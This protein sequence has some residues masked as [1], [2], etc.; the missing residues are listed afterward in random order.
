MQERRVLSDRKLEKQEVGE[1]KL[2]E[3]I[4]FGDNMN[5]AYKKVRRA[6]GAQE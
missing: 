3:K 4:L 5:R 1:P 2:L 6:K